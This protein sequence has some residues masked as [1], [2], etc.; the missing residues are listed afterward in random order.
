MPVPPTFN[1]AVFSGVQLGE[2]F[3][4]DKPRDLTIST[5]LPR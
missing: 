1:M 5:P 4:H 3:S 2:L